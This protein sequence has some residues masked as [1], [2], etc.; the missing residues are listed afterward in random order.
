MDY[1]TNQ[2][3]T[4]FEN[5]IGGIQSVDDHFVYY[6]DGTIKTI[7]QYR[8]DFDN[9]VD[10]FIYN[11]DYSN[12]DKEN[13]NAGND[14][15]EDSIGN[16]VNGVKEKFNFYND[17]SNNVKSM[18]DVITNVESVPK[19]YL[20]VNSKWYNGEVCI[21]DLSWY[22]PYKDFGDTVICIF[23]YIAFLWHVFIRLPDIINGAGA[24]SYAG[25]MVSDIETYHKTGI[26]RSSILRR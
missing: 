21:V 18:V 17:I 15:A 4:G 23:V 12:L 22:A 14:S 5:S 9:Y 2:L 13:N 26:G 11:N 1:A 25:N 19:Y 24:S 10:N 20:N 8:N 7:D 6:A 16:G 3:V